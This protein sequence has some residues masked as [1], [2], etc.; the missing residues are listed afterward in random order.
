MP[1]PVRP[2]R[3]PAS[4][5]K[6]G[7]I[8]KAPGRGAERLA[9]GLI[10]LLSV[11]VALV[12]DPGFGGV[13]RLPK[14]LLAETLG[15]A[16]LAA[17][18]LAARRFD[19]RGLLTSP[20]VVGVGPLLLVAALLAPFSRHPEHVAA[21]LAGCW[22][23]GACLVGWSLGFERQRLGRLL[24]WTLPGALLSGGL[25]VLQAL[26][27][28]QP[29]GVVAAGA[30]SPRY[31]VIGLAG[32]AGDLSASLVLPALVAQASFARRRT[33]WA[34]AAAL[35]A[36]AA[37]G[38]TQTVAPLLAIAGGSV[39]IWWPRLVRRRRW[40]FA[41]VAAGLALAGAL[42]FPE[43][44][45][46]FQ[47]KVANLVRGEWNALLTGRLDG[48]LVA[49]EMLRAEPW[50]GVGQGAYRAAFVDTKARLAERG[51][52]FFPEQPFPVF[53]NAHSEPLEVGAELGLPGLAA[54]GWLLFYLGRRMTRARFPGDAGELALGRAALAALG[55]L[56]LGGFPFRIAVVG[57]PAL[58]L[59]AFLLAGRERPA[60][61][62][63]ARVPAGAGE[64]AP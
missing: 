12:F 22:I 47:G 30:E 5:P 60:A 50:T 64:P 29:F 2:R 8:E 37:A 18:I 25:G 38:A 4:T 16:S 35:L 1:P 59:M 48:W 13:F 6:A 21:G 19:P 9:Y 56:A 17:L 27:L 39:L 54:L 11:G 20:A 14:R 62:V 43:A 36:I 28:Y 15:L 32:N 52:E 53:A 61:P 3:T 42:A 33:W 7:L 31:E 41:G 40:L 44:R 58:V 23:G 51:V 63:P 49:V 57:Y 24:L 45:E 26:D 34:A 46:R 10:A 55:L